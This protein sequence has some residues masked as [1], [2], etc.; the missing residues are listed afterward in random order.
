MTDMFRR[1]NTEGYSESDLEALNAAFERELA[2]QDTEW[3]TED[4]LTSFRKH[5]AEQVQQQF[6]L[7]PERYGA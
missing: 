3:M 1:D 4:V 7:Y 5:L 6:D 2:G